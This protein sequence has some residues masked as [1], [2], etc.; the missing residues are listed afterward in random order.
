MFTY[1]FGQMLDIGERNGYVYQVFQSHSEAENGGHVLWLAGLTSYDLPWFPNQADAI[2]WLENVAAFP[3][4][5][6]RIVRELE[7]TE[8]YAKGGPSWITAGVVHVKRTGESDYWKA[9]N[10]T[11]GIPHYWE[12]PHADWDKWPSDF[13]SVVNGQPH[14][15]VLIPG[16]GTCSVPVSIYPHRIGW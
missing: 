16:A 3:G 11:P 9:R 14:L 10:A 1:L 6:L 15:L 4:E 8:H 5:V 13:K 7:G 12:I 2:N